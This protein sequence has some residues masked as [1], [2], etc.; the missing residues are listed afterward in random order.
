MAD[1]SLEDK[2]QIVFDVKVSKKLFR[3]IAWD[4]NVKVALVQSIASKAKSNS[5]FL[6]ELRAKRDSS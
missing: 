5:S 3:D 4:H 2:T 1:L 6:K